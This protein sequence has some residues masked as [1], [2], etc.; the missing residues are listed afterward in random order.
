M[1]PLKL[2]ISAWGPY[3]KEVQIDFTKFNEDS[4]F[5]I[6]GPTGAGK[7]TIFDAISFA[8]YG[9]VS[10]K[11][12]DKNSV[13]SDFAKR[14][15][16]TFVMLEFIHKGN[17]YK[18]KRSPKFE[19]AKK[20]GT[21]NTVSNETAELYEEDLVP[22]ASVTEVN[23]KLEEIMGINYNQFKQIAMIAQGEFLELLLASSKEKVDIFRNLFKTDTYDKLQK[24]L[25]EKARELYNKITALDHRIQEDSRLIDA[26]GL[27]A[28]EE[29]LKAEYVQY[30]IICDLTKEFIRNEKKVYKD[31]KNKI[32]KKEAS[33]KGIITKISEGESLN[34]KF[35]LLSET[36]DGLEDLKKKQEEIAAWEK[37]LK[38]ADL[39]QKAIGEERIYLRVAKSLCEMKDKL[40]S[41]EK[42]LSEL[43]PKFHESKLALKDNEKRQKML[44]ELEERGKELERYLPILKELESAKQKYEDKN[45]TLLALAKDVDKLVDKTK[46]LEKEKAENSKEARQYENVAGLL[47]EAEL[48]EQETKRRKQDIYSALQLYGKYNEEESC[49]KR[50][51]EKYEK[52]SNEKEKKRE[53]FLEKEDSYQRATAG[54]LAKNLE[55][56]Q[57]CPVCGS[58]TH[59]QLATIHENV[60]DENQLK[61]FKK[62]SEE[63]EKDYNEIYQQT[64]EAKVR[65]ET[66]LGML[67]KLLIQLDIIQEENVIPLTKVSTLYEDTREVLINISK[68]KEELKK[69]SNRKAKLLQLNEKLD[70]KLVDILKDR[71]KKSEKYQQLKSECDVL[72][73][74]IAGMKS[75]LPSKMESAKG[76][77]EESIDIKNKIQKL[78]QE[79]EE[80]KN[81]HEVLKSKIENDEILLKQLKEDYGKLKKEE[82]QEKEVFSNKL[83]SL[84]FANV[85]EYHKGFLAE[86]EYKTI[87]TQVKKY[88]QEI[89]EK[90]DQIKNL[91]EETKG[92][93]LI[94]LTDLNE[95]LDREEKEKGLLQDKKEEVGTRIQMNKKARESIKEKLSTKEVLDQEYGIMQDLDNVTK[96]K[97]LDRV[98]FEHYVLSSYFEDILRIA[99][100]KLLSM[101]GSRYELM[102]VEKVADARTKDSLDLEVL[103]NYTGKKRSVKTLSGGES[104]KAALSLA[105]GLSDIVQNNAGGI[106]ID[107]LFIDEGFGALDDESLDQ[108][109]NTLTTLADQNRLIGIIS[110]VNELKE[111]I[112]QQIIIKKDNFGSSLGTL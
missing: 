28:L 32:E 56:T 92:K 48:K 60:P 22:I 84:G 44:E 82:L 81:Q 61:I 65:A 88:N 85:E 15:L 108:A 63:A 49:L 94:N 89:Q 66:S 2:I 27:V 59:P 42:N 23:K 6:T 20:R 72:N 111:R 74:N 35:D 12:R 69:Q 13:R 62:E 73:G 24:K 11:V 38:T 103:D 76:M 47:G 16:D 79:I 37:R 87:Q 31:L 93:E 33:S 45:S 46:E 70:E 102:K 78:E 80:I 101:T 29:A 39:V 98:V 109:L 34:K 25:S 43:M 97:N 41:K 58:C 107:T 77:K 112:D 68:H 8:L 100:K 67:T 83:E 52:A 91:Q 106:R 95:E 104:F 4:L 64:R 40:S 10:G 14:E 90:D 1:K 3:P 7:T 105:L 5:L 57:P 75:K 110:H 9:N 71:E 55:D 19:R 96:G 17:Y 36:I 26:N 51:Q 86:G 18:I 53:I 54:L 30:D 50:Y 99:N 21:G